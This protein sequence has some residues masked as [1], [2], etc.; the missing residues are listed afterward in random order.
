MA[1]CE[2]LPPSTDTSWEA[3]SL[4]PPSVPPSTKVFPEQ[5]ISPAWSNT[6][7]PKSSLSLTIYD[8]L[9]SQVCCRCSHTSLFSCRHTPELSRRVAVAARM[10]QRRVYIRD[11]VPWIDLLAERFS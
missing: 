5:A 2:T 8:R 1:S 11:D 4:C 10:F 6:I 9:P 7:Q 3:T